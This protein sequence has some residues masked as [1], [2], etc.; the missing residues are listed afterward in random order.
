MLSLKTWTLSAG[1]WMA[2]TFAIC[3]FGGVLVPSLPIPHRSL[4]LLLP[5]FV[6]ISPGSFV[7][8]LVETFLF[9]VYAAWLF[10]T[11]HNF[12]ARRETRTI[13]VSQAA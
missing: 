7:L 6:W 3:V 8:G 9:G 5:G 1:C 4:E 11:L 10:V 12:F 2:I 13:R